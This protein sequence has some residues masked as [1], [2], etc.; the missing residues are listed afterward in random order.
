MPKVAEGITLNNLF[1]YS[2]PLSS[3][4]SRG[5]DEIIRTNFPNF[6]REEYERIKDEFYHLT[7]LIRDLFVVKFPGTIN[8]YDSNKGNVLVSPLLE[9]IEGHKYMLSLIDL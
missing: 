2:H 4:N 9:P 1:L 8:N 6:G 3:R 7:S 5:V